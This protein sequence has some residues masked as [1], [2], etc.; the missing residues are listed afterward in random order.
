MASHIEDYAMIGDC[1]TAALVSKDGS[2]DWLCLPRF[3]SGACFA[4]LLGAPDHGRWSLAPTSPPTRVARRYRPD[5]LILETE[6]QTGEGSVTLIDFMPLREK[7]PQLVRLVRGDRGEVQM[8]MELILR[9]DYGDLVRWVSRL[10]DE[11]L[12]ALAG[13]HM[14]VLRTP[15][16]LRGEDLKTVSEFTVKAGET[17]PFVL[18]YAPSH[19]PV[20]EK[21][22]PQ[23]ALNRTHEF[24]KEWISVCTYRGPYAEV[25]KRSLITLKGLTYLPTGG[26]TAAPTTSLRE[27]IGGPRN[28]ITATAAAGRHTYPAGITRKWLP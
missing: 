26:I 14:V 25:V 2:M 3:D 7:Y 23:E 15:A 18:T 9:F 10:E 19:L 17:I 8:S 22:D 27:K 5:T 20:P 28:W 21:I 24:W 6:F 1:E 16:P 12:H 4:A 11:S 13:S